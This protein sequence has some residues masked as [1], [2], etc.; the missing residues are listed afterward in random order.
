MDVSCH[1]ERV[2]KNNLVSLITHETGDT[3]VSVTLIP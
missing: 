3:E 2:T 1:P